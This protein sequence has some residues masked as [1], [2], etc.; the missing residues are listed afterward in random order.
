[1]NFVDI[2]VFVIVAFEMLISFRRGMVKTVIEMAG[3]IVALITAKLY[4]GVLAAYL[5][6]KYSVFKNLETN[7][8]KTLSEHLTTQTQVQA[9]AQTGHL[10][11]TVQLPSVLG[12]I[13]KEFLGGSSETINQMVYGDLAH[14]LSQLIIN[15]ISFM[16]I[17]FGVLLVIGV[18]SHMAELV[19]KLPLLREANKLGGL[20]IGLVKGCFNVLVLMTV[21]TFILPFMKQTWLIDGILHSQYGVYFY[22][23]NILLYFIYY[24]LR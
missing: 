1:M 12:A 10:G 4:Y 15:G 9:A 24:L 2:A 19:M 23:N 5:V 21:I 16:T 11:G 3:W 6:S 8:Y 14:K 13:P 18:L 17:A 20:A 22:N 7:I